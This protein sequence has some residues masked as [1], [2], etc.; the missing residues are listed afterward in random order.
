MN[1][2]QEL[3]KYKFLKTAGETAEQFRIESF[4]VGGF[5][6]DLILKGKAAK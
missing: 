6:R 2:K 5:I 3:S 1:L 4:I